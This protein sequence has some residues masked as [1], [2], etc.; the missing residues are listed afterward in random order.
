VTLADV[1]HL[2]QR[3]VAGL[4]VTKPEAR[5]DKVN[6]LIYGESG[7][8]KTILAGSADEVPEMRPVLLIDA[9]AGTL[10]LDKYY[11]NVDVVRV[12]T[13]H[14]LQRLY[15]ELRLGKTPYQT[16]ILDSITELQKFGMDHIMKSPA[17]EVLSL[18]PDGIPG[19]KEWGINT[20]QMRRT[21][22][23]FR[24]LDMHT[25]VTALIKDDKNPRTGQVTMRPALSGQLAREVP[26]F[27]D[28]VAYMYVK[29]VQEGDSIEQKRLL[30]TQATDMQVAKDRTGRL[31]LVMES[32]T[33]TDIY[34]VLTQ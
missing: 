6:I 23:A 15:D 1:A 22:R 2:D 17:A 3:S 5:R 14:E 19:L 9:E 7:V 29:N 12:K 25:I 16:V 26:A 21:I 4:T 31:P 13:M 10:S 11:P 8:G 34:G 27:L 18:M 28:V 30:L 20:E 32:P 24:D 33:M